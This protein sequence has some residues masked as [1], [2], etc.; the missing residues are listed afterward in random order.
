MRRSSWRGSGGSFIGSRVVIVEVFGELLPQR[1][2]ALIMVPQTTASSKIM[3]WMSCGSCAQH[4]NTASPSALAKR[5][6]LAFSGFVD[7]A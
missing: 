1:F 3:C 7:I 6:R 2:I 4:S 5:S